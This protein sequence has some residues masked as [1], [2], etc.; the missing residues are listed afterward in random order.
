MPLLVSMMSKV[1]RPYLGGADSP[2]I[3]IEEMN[4]RIKKIK[5]WDIDE[6]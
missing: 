5:H 2:L 4:E 1:L 3:N 6:N